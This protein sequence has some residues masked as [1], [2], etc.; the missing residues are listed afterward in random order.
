MSDVNEDLIR[1]LYAK[2]APD[3]DVD[4]KIEHIQT[5]YGDNQDSFVE[6][7]YRKYSPDTEVSSKL[8]YI[9]SK[10]PVDEVKKKEET[11][12]IEEKELVS[13][14][15]EEVTESTTEVGN[16]STSQASVL[17][18]EVKTP[19]GTEV[20]VEEQIP[21]ISGTSTPGIIKDPSMLPASEVEQEVF[22]ESISEIN[23]DSDLK[24]IQET[25]MRKVVGTDPQGEVMSV[26]K[27]G[28]SNTEALS[29]QEN[30]VTDFANLYIKADEDRFVDEEKV[31]DNINTSNLYK[32]KRKLEADIKNIDM[33][34]RS[35]L[36]FSTGEKII[37]VKVEELRGEDKTNYQNFKLQKESLSKELD[38][39]TKEWS[40]TSNPLLESDDK[41]QKIYDPFTG[42]FILKINA[43]APVI[44]YTDNVNAEA[45]KISETTG[46]EELLKIRTDLYYDILNLSKQVKRN[47]KDVLEERTFLGSIVDEG[48]GLVNKAAN[49][50]GVEFD[51][52]RDKNIE[53]Q[54]ERF[55]DEKDNNFKGVIPQ[56]MSEHPLAKQLN[57]KV[58]QFDA[59]NRAVELNKFPPVQDNESLIDISGVESGFV[60]TLFGEEY[61]KN[62]D[63]SFG[64]GSNDFRVK[65]T[66]AQPLA[67]VL[68]E[69]GFSGE[70]IDELQKASELTFG[71]EAQELTGNIG[72]MVLELYGTGGAVLKSTKIPKVLE[73]FS[74]LSKKKY[75]TWAGL[76]ADVLAGG[77]TEGTKFGLTGVMLDK[78]EEYDPKLGIAFG[79]LSPLASV[80][81]SLLSKLPAAKVVDDV[82]SASMPG[83]NTGK[84]VVGKGA[85]AAVGVNV[86]YGADLFDKIVF[87]GKQSGIAW[88]EVVYG[89]T[90]EDPEGVDPLRKASQLWGVMLATGLAQKNTYRKFHDALGKDILEARGRKIDWKW[91]KSQAP[92]PPEGEAYTENMLIE[93]GIEA[94]NKNG[95]AADKSKLVDIMQ[96]VSY[97]ENLNAAKEQ[98][99]DVT[100]QR[101]KQE[102]QNSGLKK[103]TK[104]VVKGE[105][106]PTEVN[107]DA[108]EI[109]S[110]ISST[111]AELKNISNSV[112]SQ[113]KNNNITAAEGQDVINKVSEVLKNSSEIGVQNS[114]TKS[115]VIEK[116]NELEGIKAEAEELDKLKFR[117]EATQKELNSLN[118]RSNEIESELKTI[119]ETP[120]TTSELLTDLATNKNRREKTLRDIKWQEDNVELVSEIEAKRR[121]GLN[122]NQA[123][124]EL[125]KEY[126]T[127][128]VDEV[129]TIKDSQIPLSKDIYTIRTEPGEGVRTVEVTVK[130]DGSRTVEQKVDG[131]TTAGSQNIPSTNTVS[132]MDFVS[133]SFGEVVGTP[134]TL[135]MEKVMNSKMKDKLT[136]KQKQDLG[137]SK[138]VSLEAAPEPVELEVLETDLTIYKG[139]GGKRNAD[140]T[141]KTRH[142]DVEGKF[143]SEDIS[144]AEKYKGEK[145]VI[146]DIIPKGAT[147]ETVEIDGSKFSPGKAYDQAETDAINASKADVVKLITNDQN[148]GRQTQI[149]IKTKKD[150]VQKPSTKEVDVRQQAEDGGA[151]AKGDKVEVASEEVKEEAKE[152]AKEK[153]VETL[154]KDLARE[155]ASE[156]KSE[157]VV[158]DLKEKLAGYKTQALKKIKPTQKP[159]AK[160]KAK[161]KTELQELAQQLKR[162][163]KVSERALDLNKETITKIDE[164]LKDLEKEYKELGLPKQKYTPAQV[165]RIIKSSVDTKL[166]QDKIDEIIEG[167]NQILDPIIRKD[168]IRYLKNT[169]YSPKKLPKISVE[170]RKKL[171]EIRDDLKVGDLKNK[172]TEELKALSEVVTEII[173]EGKASQD[174]LQRLQNITRYKK[175]ADVSKDLYKKEEFK[176]ISTIEELDKFFNDNPNGFVLLNDT[177]EVTPGNYKSF[178]NDN[179][180][181]PIEG[182]KAY[183]SIDLKQVQRDYVR[184]PIRVLRG[185]INPANQIAT[186]EN[187]MKP[188]WR[189]APKVREILEPVV[190]Q[191]KNAY[192]N[193]QVA[194]RKYT[195]MY[196][197]YLAD[198]FGSKKKGVKELSKTVDGLLNPTSKVVSKRGTTINNGQVGRYIAI[199]NLYK[200]RATQMREDAQELKGTAKD[201]LLNKADKFDKILERSGVNEKEFDK[202]IEANPKIKEFGD[203]L[204]KVFEEM[205]PDFAPTYEKATNMVFEE[206]L[207]VPD[208]KAGKVDETGIVGATERLK[209]LDEGGDFITRSALSNR[210]KERTDNADPI[211][212]YLDATNMFISYVR[213]MSHAKEMMPIAE[214]INEVFNKPNIGAIYQKLGKAKFESLMEALDSQINLN[215]DP[216]KSLEKVIL[217]L[218]RFGIVTNLAISVKNIPKQAVSFINYSVA[219]Y[220]DGINPVDWAL[221]FPKM[222]STK[223]GREIAVRILQSPYLKER[224]KKTQVDPLLSKAIDGLDKNST[225]NTI[226]NTLQKIAMSPIMMGDAIGVVSGGVPFAVAVHKQK[227]REGMSFEDA[228]N[229]TYK[230]FVEES[231]ESQQTSADY[232]LGK[233]ARSKLGKLFVTYKTA[234]TS[235][236]NKVLGA[237]EDTRDWKNLNNKQKKQAIADA[238]FFSVMWSVPFLAV[239]N[240]IVNA[241]INDEGDEVKERKS[242]ELL[243]DAI[244]SNLQGLGL[245]GY[246][247]NVAY[248]IIT[249]KPAE[250]SLPPIASWFLNTTETLNTLSKKGIN[251]DD[252]SDSEMKKIKKA[253][254]AKNVTDL[255]KN[256]TDGQKSVYDAI[257]NYQEGKV[258]PNR[259]RDYM[260]GVDPDEEKIVTPMRRGYR[261]SRTSRTNRTNRTSRTN[262]TNRN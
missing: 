173:T 57:E 169:L 201:N 98:I 203:N 7:F 192:T 144:T 165:R 228:W 193:N 16:E 195:N 253:L 161:P 239:G 164:I 180:F 199:Q 14:S 196:N 93:S 223:N 171:K 149:I 155:E 210:M 132:N 25:T 61:G 2:Y 83:Y 158:K 260:L 122:T 220:K 216:V 231:N 129:E 202:Y 45:R 104:D 200:K 106:E 162:D 79:V 225:Y 156:F 259:L 9:N 118:E 48:T 188:L 88:D 113:V 240:G 230:R 20:V 257:M 255:Y 81:S 186:I 123:L 178:L 66:Q 191:I 160:S 39:V 206:E 111:P 258:Y 189:G 8:D 96:D 31:E 246:V 49:F 176:E 53:L 175:Q 38:K 34:M 37:P 248:N 110:F 184:N 236:M 100:N 115:V 247:G 72:G 51:N 252:Y 241:F 91:V 261:T 157:E 33:E 232:A 107:L 52:P 243:L 60:S 59:V 151:V 124:K 142:P 74:V 187:L 137:I 168:N 103:I 249:E 55:P 65:V 4:S 120:E 85:E 15:Q 78:Q 121:G 94:V 109:N 127:K 43:P 13:D 23:K 204:Y 62:P 80:G 154:E 12:E 250:W 3:V 234:Q 77:A 82:L 19:S 214:N 198:I 152:K 28:I 211:D 194:R 177:Y 41:S 218:N 238:I 147:I 139:T 26:N 224:I 119:S 128:E 56:I 70:A 58:R 215:A 237:Y 1:N 10:Y 133:L 97:N 116:I 76:A 227:M 233:V 35:L 242:V 117:D 256:L 64:S 46:E 87:D 99:Q 86:I 130:K 170:S 190:K 54:L 44:Q 251:F 105:V 22:T 213:S 68:K 29:I 163:S 47:K 150:A 217:E 166:T 153:I 17:E 32:N 135:P 102:K 108:G 50:I 183:T 84:F 254:G 18:E 125:S 67:N 208:N 226:T 95:T 145:E 167:V 24:N 245:P 42:Q 89:K 140:G 126:E 185:K 219:G 141:I 11:E 138:E 5:T 27:P 90:P 221:G 229:Y 75:G 6:S 207:Y 40:K 181:L 262:R 179:P 222:L 136:K 69:K 197:N 174:A 36:Q 205:A 21:G 71:E 235:A 134:E 63:I 73:T 159:K 209:T 131:V 114:K 30:K 112:K 182:T 92:K 143:Y 244:N 146:S 101:D 212:L 148:G 172:T